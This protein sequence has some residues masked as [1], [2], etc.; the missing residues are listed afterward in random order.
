VYFQILT[1]ILKAWPAHHG[2]SPFTSLQLSLPGR[3]AD[4]P[5]AAG[6]VNLEPAMHSA[7]AGAGLGRSDGLQPL[8]DRSTSPAT[9]Q[10]PTM[11]GASM[12]PLA[13]SLATAAGRRHGFRGERRHHGGIRLGFIA[14]SPGATRAACPAPSG[15]PPAA[16]SRSDPPDPRPA[17]RAPL[18]QRRLK[19]DCRSARGTSRPLRETRPSSARCARRLRSV[20]IRQRAAVMVVLRELQGRRITVSHT[21]TRDCVRMASSKQLLRSSP[22]LR[23]RR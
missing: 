12:P 10:R 16:S 7:K 22:L 6:K 17:H 14:R 3:A 15:V 8:R 4:R 13:Q 9:F 23:S 19:W 21:S 1:A 11:I 18:R 2:D 20:R 5:F